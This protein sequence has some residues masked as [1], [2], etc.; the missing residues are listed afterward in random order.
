MGQ[1]D[2]VLRVDQG[3]VRWS[4]GPVLRQNDLVILSELILKHRHGVLVFIFV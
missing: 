4:D 1:V 2:S 3:V